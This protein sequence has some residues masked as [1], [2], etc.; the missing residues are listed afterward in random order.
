[1]LL[2]PEQAYFLR[3]NVR[4]TLL[5][6]R[7]GLLARQFDSARADV[8]TV[9]RHLRRYFEIDA[10]HMRQTLETLAALQRDLRQ[11][12]LP[13]PDETLAALSAAAGGR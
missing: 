12:T 5:N 9:E 3:E 7:L 4:L 8:R 6:A 13:R 10:P 2:A 11:E 1:M